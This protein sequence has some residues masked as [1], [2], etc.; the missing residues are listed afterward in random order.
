MRDL[1]QVATAVVLAWIAVPVTAQSGYPDYDACVLK[2]GDE[3]I[4]GCTAAIKSGKI[5]GRDLAAMFYNRGDAY[6]TQRKYELAIA[7]FS[8]AMRISPPYAG[9]RYGRG[10]AEAKLGQDA[11]SKAD[12]AGAL[13]IDP[14]VAAAFEMEDT[15]TPT[16][17]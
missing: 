1:W 7:D 10:L 15:A 16:K 14:G 2:S 9:A 12:L 6:R 11:A 5:V 17:P 13:R 3:A 8:E 4:A